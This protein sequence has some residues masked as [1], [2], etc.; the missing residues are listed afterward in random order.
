MW[1]LKGLERALVLLCDT[2]DFLVEGPCYTP[3]LLLNL[4]SIRYICWVP[5][6]AEAKTS[7]QAA[8]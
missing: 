1:S 6:E 3:E 2:V 4:G 5:E 7:T 8:F